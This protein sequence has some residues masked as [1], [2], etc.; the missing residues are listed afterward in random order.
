MTTAKIALLVGIL[1]SCFAVGL[2]YGVAAL[3]GTR[4][5][6]DE[7]ARHVLIAFVIGTT[8]I[9]VMRRRPMA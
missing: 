6:N 8:A 9:V 3:Q 2:A 4:P 7:L 5:T 1:G